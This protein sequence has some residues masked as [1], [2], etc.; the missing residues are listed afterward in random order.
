MRAF[1]KY[2]RFVLKISSK[3]DIVCYNCMEE[4][5]SIHVRSLRKHS[6]KKSKVGH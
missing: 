3:L 4:K 6:Y 5:L 2:S 1:R